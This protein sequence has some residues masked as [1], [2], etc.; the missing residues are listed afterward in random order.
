MMRSAPFVVTRPR[1][2]QAVARRV[3][4][5]D[6][7]AID[8]EANG[9]HAFRPRL[10]VVQLAWR[11][12]ADIVAAIV[13]ALSLDLEP[14]APALGAGGP[15]KLLHD[16]TFDVRM[17]AERGLNLD[18]VR[19]TSVQARLLGERATG[20]ATLVASRLDIQL[21]KGLQHHN[22]AERPFEHRHIRYLAGDVIHLEALDQRLQAEVYEAAIADEVE[23]ETRYKLA[24]AKQ[25]PGDGR[26]PYTRVKGFPALD[27]SAQA[28]LRR[29]FTVRDEI[30]ERQDVP[31]HKV[32]PPS[33][34]LELARRQ[35]TRASEVTRWCRR[36]RG[37]RLHV[38]RWRDAIRQ[39]L[40][41]GTPP[42]LDLPPPRG[43]GLSPVEVTRRK[44]MEKALSRWRR[45][46]ARARGVVA[47][48][49]V[50]GHAMGPV[51]RA[52]LAG[53]DGLGVRLAAIPGLGSWRAERHIDAWRVIRDEALA[54]AVASPSESPPP[55]LPSSPAAGGGVVR[56]VP[57]PAPGTQPWLRDRRGDERDHPL[58]SGDVIQR[59]S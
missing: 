26:P 29:L 30:A 15:L 32:A 58:A 4:D 28:V 3:R 25:P 16:L 18:R 17:L 39:G 40:E 10:C 43:Q 49:I 21:T 50:P 53:D 55:P 20:L 57:S 5:V 22:W 13:D 37:A 56:P 31:A 6:R 45:E 1:T 23:L 36:H 38:D 8:V 48:V 7:L 34:L 42:L 19:D 11:E 46:A 27:P 51:V 59:S 24:T 52:L 2:L 9:M 12:G 47:Q 35:P 44:V 41:D 14:L 33:L 54:T